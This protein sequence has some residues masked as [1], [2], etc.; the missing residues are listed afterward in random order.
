ME[1]ERKRYKGK[2]PSED[3]LHL[4][5]KKQAALEKQRRKVKRNEDGF[6]IIKRK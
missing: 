6:I 1:S 5:R 4:I 2:L 3:E